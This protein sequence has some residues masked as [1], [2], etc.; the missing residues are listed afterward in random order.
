MAFEMKPGQGSAFK[1]DKKELEWHAD[2]KGKVMLPDG[3]TAW[4]DLTRKKTIAGE[5][6]VQVKIRPMEN[7]DAEPMAHRAAAPAASPPRGAASHTGMD[8]DVPFAPER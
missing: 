1:N 4:I 5:P 6:W 2:Y 8:D 7:R 3:T